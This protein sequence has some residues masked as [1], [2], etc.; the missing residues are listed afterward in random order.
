[1]NFDFSALNAAQLDEL[2]AAAA[3]RRA[4]LS[5]AHDMQPP[6]QCEAIVNPAWHTAPMPDGL[7]FM[8]RH[9]GLGWLGF[10]LAHEHR[11]HLATLWLHQSMLHKPPAAAAPTAPA[12]APVPPPTPAAGAGGSGS[13]H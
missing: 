1:M 13:V 8:L 6:A 12:P 9:P 7:L 3:K 10:A 4:E 2:I 5:P 11:V